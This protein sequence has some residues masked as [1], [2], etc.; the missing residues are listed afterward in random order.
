M[1]PDHPHEEYWKVAE[2]YSLRLGRLAL[3]LCQGEEEFARD[4]TQ[5]TLANTANCDDLQIH[6]D[7][8]PLFRRVMLNAHIDRGR[9]KHREKPLLDV[10]LQANSSD[11]GSSIDLKWDVRQA[12]SALTDDQARLLQ[13]VYGQGHSLEEASYLLQITPEAVKQRLKRARHQFRKA[14]ER[15]GEVIL[16]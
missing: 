13:L 12:L 4:L 3:R 8:W 2:T 11:P 16:K 9:L 7:I 14:F 10:E 1:G 15:N 6:R 5:Q